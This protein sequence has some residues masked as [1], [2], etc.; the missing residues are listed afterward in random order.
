MTL[1]W[2]SASIRDRE[3][4]ACYLFEEGFVEVNVVFLECGAV[5]S[6]VAN[7]F[8]ANHI[9]TNYHFVKV[10]FVHLCFNFVFNEF[11]FGL[12]FLNNFLPFVKKFK[13]CE[14]F[15]FRHFSY[16]LFF[17]LFVF[18]VLPLPY[19]YYYTLI[20]S[21]FQFAEYTNFTLNSCVYLTLDLSVVLCYNRDSGKGGF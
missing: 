5:K 4:F 19:E 14:H 17:W 9:R 18:E 2:F 7:G 21:V 10:S 8:V 16:L 13:F 1:F 6:A 3:P 12:C 15:V 20:S 11:G